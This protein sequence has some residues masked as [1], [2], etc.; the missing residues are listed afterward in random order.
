M[1][2]SSVWSA[3]WISVMLCAYPL[4]MHATYL[5]S[6]SSLTGKRLVWIELAVLAMVIIAR[7]RRRRALAILAVIAAALV[8]A[9]RSTTGDAIIVASGVP[10]AVAYITLLF[11]FGSSL[12]P[13]RVPVISL[14]SEKLSI[15][16]LSPRLLRYT[17]NVT[18][19]WGCFFAA[20]LLISGILFW[21]ASTATWSLFVN[22][23][24]LPL[25]LAVFAA[26]YT[27][28]RLRFPFFRHRTF[29]EIVRM[30]TDKDGFD[31]RVWR[32]GSNP[33]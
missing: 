30:L 19:L 11:I 28:R 16:P 9:V 32:L 7:F 14:L 25:N 4:V 13:G 21:S 27:Y 10:H 3:R 33:P 15:E 26:E 2:A 6:R 1:R 22:V 8:L 12:L 31:W 29:A 17:R 20:Q 23:L 5:W 18:I 24:N